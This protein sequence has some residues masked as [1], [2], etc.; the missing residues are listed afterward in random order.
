VIRGQRRL[1]ALAPWVAMLVLNFFD[2]MLWWSSNW[3]TAILFALL[4]AY[5]AERPGAR[6]AG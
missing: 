5:M 3:Q 6:A 2:T 4:I 1:A